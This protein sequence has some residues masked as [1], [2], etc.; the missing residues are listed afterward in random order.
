MEQIKHS[1]AILISY[2]ESKKYYGYDPYDTLNSNIPFN[3]AGKYLSAVV[4]QIQKRNPLNIRPLLGIK[5]EINPKGMGLF[6]KAYSILYRK[7]G[8][9]KYLDKAG[10]ILHWLQNNYSDGFSGK[11][12]GYNFDWASPGSYLKAYTPS[13]VV[14]SFV[15]DGIFEYYKTTKDHKAAESILSASKYIINDIA[16]L[17]FDTGISFSYT[18]LSKGAC[19]NASLLASEIL[20]KANAVENNPEKISLIKDAVSFVL[21]KQKKDGSWYY[22]I[23]PGTNKERKQIDFHQGFILVSLQN[24]LTLTGILQDEIKSAITKGLEFYKKEQFLENGQSLWRL[25]KKWPVDIHNQSQGIITF[26]SLKQYRS[27]YIAFAKTIALWTIDNMQS[28]KG[29]FYFRKTPLLV[30]KIPYMR[31]SQA[32]MMVALSELLECEE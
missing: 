14:T 7:T 30:N 28:Q 19:Y 1:I 23:E 21:S 9:K 10:E 20:A 22:S 12:W 2:I 18:H 15:I 5:K 17:K 8:K 25:P 16:V 13:V 29:F 32:W 24:I 11:C 26:S 4:I 27:D 6:L 31:W 3:L